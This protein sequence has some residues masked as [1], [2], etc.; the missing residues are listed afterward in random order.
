MNRD[1]VFLLGALGFDFGL[2]VSLSLGVLLS[3]LE[4]LYWGK[5]TVVHPSNRLQTPLYFL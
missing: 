4:S 5:V 1:D 3:E 2:V